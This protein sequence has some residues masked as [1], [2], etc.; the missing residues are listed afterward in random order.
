M[1]PP[2]IGWVMVTLLLMA[3]GAFFWAGVK[4]ARQ[5]FER[6]W[7]ARATYEIELIES[8]LDSLQAMS[9][10]S[11]VLWYRKNRES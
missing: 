8:R 1:R 10:S 5:L 9:D 6:G 2:H 11:C 3:A 4:A 7:E